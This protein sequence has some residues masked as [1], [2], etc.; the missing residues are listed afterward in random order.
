MGGTV[1]KVFNQATNT[2]Q[3]V[4]KSEPKPV[5][6][7]GDEQAAARRRARRGGRSLLSDVRLNPEQ[8]VGQSTLGA[9]PMQ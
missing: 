3:E 4:V 8:G 6:E 5:S 7:S 9:G 2:V 1:R